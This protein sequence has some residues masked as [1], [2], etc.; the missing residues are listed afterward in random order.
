MH[1]Y[2]HASYKLKHGMRMERVQARSLERAFA[3]RI[4]KKRPKPGR[5]PVLALQQLQYALWQ[6]VRLGHHRGAC[7][8]QD[9][10]AREVG[11]FH[12][13]VRI[14]NTRT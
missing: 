9:L 7:L 14:L 11:G 13:K 12:R 3:R 8:L 4:S 10:G 5:A 1:L 2:R 6:L